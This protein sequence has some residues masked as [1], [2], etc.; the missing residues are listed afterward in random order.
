MLS[1]KARDCSTPIQGLPNLRP[2]PLYS[3]KKNTYLFNRWNCD[4]SGTDSQ[5][6]LGSSQVE[7][8][9]AKWECGKCAIGFNDGIPYAAFAC[10][11]ALIVLGTPYQTWRAREKLS[12]GRVGVVA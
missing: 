11:D 7:A 2:V 6:I 10:S 3:R 12:Y 1:F 9:L 4:G 8:E 5:N